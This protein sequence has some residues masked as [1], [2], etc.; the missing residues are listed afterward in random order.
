M[1]QTIGLPAG[2]DDSLARQREELR[3]RLQEGD[4]VTINPVN[5]ST[6]GSNIETVVSVEAPVAPQYDLGRLEAVIL[7]KQATALTW[8]ELNF[9]AQYSQN[10]DVIFEFTEFDSTHYITLV[11][12]FENGATFLDMMFYGAQWDENPDVRLALANCK[13]KFGDKDILRELA[14]DKDPRVR[15]AALHNPNLVKGK[16]CMITIAIAASA[17]MTSLIAC[18]CI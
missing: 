9:V 17:A 14:K 16:G 3:R 18:S 13:R 11:R 15:N 7:N 5:Q 8:Q 4:V 6:R 1:N 10:T 2:H 12:R